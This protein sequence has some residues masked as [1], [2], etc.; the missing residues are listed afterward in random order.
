MGTAAHRRVP[1]D[2]DRGPRQQRRS[3]DADGRRPVAPDRPAAR[4]GAGRARADGGHA[5]RRHL[6]CGGWRA[7][8]HVRPPQAAHRRERLPRRNGDR[9]CR[10]DVRRSDAAG[11][12]A[13][14]HVRPR[15]GVGGLDAGISVTHPRP[16]S[17][18]GDTG[19]LDAW[20]DQRQPRSSDR[21][22][23]RRRAHRPHRRRRGVL[24]QRGNLPRLRRCGVRMASQGRGDHATAGALRLG[25]SGRRPLRA[26]FAGDAENARA[27]GA[28][29]GSGQRVVGT[30]PVGGDAASEIGRQ[31]LRI[32]PRS[33]RNRRRGG[34]VPPAPGPRKA[35]G[36]RPA[37]GREP[38]LR[39]GDGRGRPRPQCRRC[40][41]GYCSQWGSPGLPCS[42]R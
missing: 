32:A 2:M 1:R 6:R 19:R 35:V 18:E 25:A 23:D 13:D 12:A 24:D 10:A 42:P 15:F 40:A 26:V 21:A 37:G 22:G 11:A 38:C 17:A 8:G 39:S 30:A 36:E 9:P 41:G 31:R 27:L 28:F 34:L 33:A 3:V 16:R 20:F 29:P 5:P 7:R 4:L 14:I